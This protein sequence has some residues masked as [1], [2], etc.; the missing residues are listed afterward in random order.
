MGIG[1]HQLFYTKRILIVERTK[2]SFNDSDLIDN[3]ITGLSIRCAFAVKE[4]DME[5]KRERGTRC[6]CVC[7]M[8]DRPHRDRREPEGAK[9][10]VWHPRWLINRAASKLAPRQRSRRSS[11]VATS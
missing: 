10:C 3:Y 11:S 7:E 4:R 1:L 9:R 6:P 2:C 5:G 8:L